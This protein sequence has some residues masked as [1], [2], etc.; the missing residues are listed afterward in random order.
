MLVELRGHFCECVGRSVGHGHPRILVP[1]PHGGPW[2]AARASRGPDGYLRG[3]VWGA[4]GGSGVVM[5]DDAG[6]RGICGAGM[7]ICGAGMGICGA[8]PRNRDNTVLP[9]VHT[10]TYHG[11]CHRKPPETAHRAPAVGGVWP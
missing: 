6:R 4:R 10:V 8:K 9:A 1:R 11:A 5:L 7:G 3:Q 2:R